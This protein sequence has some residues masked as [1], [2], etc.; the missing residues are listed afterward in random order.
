MYMTI[1]ISWNPTRVN[2]LFLFSRSR[3]K[4]KRSIEFRHSTRNVSKIAQWETQA[5]PLGPSANFD[6]CVTTRN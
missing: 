2:V 1:N 4:T 5:L 6:L 3:K